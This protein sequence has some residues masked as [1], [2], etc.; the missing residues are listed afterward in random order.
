MRTIEQLVLPARSQCTG[1]IRRLIILV[2]DSEYDCHKINNS[3]LTQDES[4]AY[5]QQHGPLL[6]CSQGCTQAGIM[7]QLYPRIQPL[8]PRM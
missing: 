8:Y 2:R 7:E 4:T 3:A 5:D 6:H 1:T